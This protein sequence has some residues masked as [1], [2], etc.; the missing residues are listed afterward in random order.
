MFDLDKWQEIYVTLSRNK[1]RTFL[2]AFGVFW[3]IFMLLIMIGAGN[4]L[5]NGVNERFNSWASNSVFV[6][7]NTTSMEYKGFKPGR[8][9]E[10]TN[11]DISAIKRNIQEVDIIAP[12]HRL[13]QYWANNKVSKGIKSG[14]YKINGDQ[15]EYAKIESYKMQKG[16]FIN[17]GD[18][19]E[20]RKVAVIGHKIF[21]Q[22]FSPNEDPIGQ[23]LQV[24]EVNFKIIGLL[25]KPTRSGGEQSESLIVP[26]STFQYT[27]NMGNKVGWF[28]ITA[29]PNVK[30]SDMQKRV[31]DL[32]KSR[33]K[34]HPEDKQ[35]LGSWNLED[36]YNRTNN[37]FIGMNWLSW[38]VGILTLVAG[39]I[40]V[41]NIMLIIIK[42]RT[43]EIGIRRAIGA[44]PWAIVS[45][46]ISESIVLTFL[47]GYFG[48]VAGIGLL[49]IINKTMESMPQ[50][51]DSASFF[52]NPGVDLNIALTALAVIIASGILAGLIPAK[53][54]LSIKP[55]EA[56]RAE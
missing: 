29:K 19:S 31:L 53:K 52:K 55:V 11:D 22:L 17:D 39:I 5:K 8:T 26:F 25:K 35:A 51:P 13:G 10:F 3:A 7:S 54:A 12:R 18:M 48:L 49:E 41:S 14:N 33:H 43:K 46:I 34:I 1:L 47:A 42:E 50:N 32:L 21:E 27:F 4:G 28:G 23:Y 6:W 16:R 2:T 45:Q 36:E 40:G 24:N 44:S 20:K 37:L 38:F 56:L 15:P 30:A 9:I